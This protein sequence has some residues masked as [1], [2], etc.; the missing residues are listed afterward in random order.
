MNV[1][2][3]KSGVFFLYRYGG[4]RKK[5][6]WNTLYVDLRSQR[7]VV[8]NVA[9]SGIAWLL[10]PGGKIAHSTFSLRWLQMKIQL[11]TLI[12]KALKK[13]CFYMLN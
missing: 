1:V 5:F 8:W 13:N 3:S 10:L 7:L 11:A 6:V 12:K 2:H 9:S 4:T